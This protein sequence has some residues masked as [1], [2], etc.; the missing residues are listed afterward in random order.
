MYTSMSYTGLTRRNTLFIFLWLRHR[1]TWTS[2]QHIGSG[3]VRTQEKTWC[4]NSRYRRKLSRTTDIVFWERRD[5]RYCVWQHGSGSVYLQSLWGGG[6]RTSSPPSAPPPPS[7]PRAVP[8]PGRAKSIPPCAC[9][10]GAWWREWFGLHTTSIYY[11]IVPGSFPNPLRVRSLPERNRVHLAP[12][13]EDVVAWVAWPLHDCHYQY[14]ILNG[15]T[16]GPGGNNVGF[17]FGFTRARA[18]GRR[19]ARGRRQLQRRG[20]GERRVAIEI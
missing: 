1:N 14:G 10:G 4:S 12:A 6:R 16:G 20:L 7:A 3:G 19:L 2:I 11:R 9:D 13:T 5:R 18:W 8:G 15:K 17:G